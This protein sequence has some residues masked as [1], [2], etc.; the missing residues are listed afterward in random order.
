MERIASPDRDLGERYGVR[1][2][3]LLILVNVW[4]PIA[5][6]CPDAG[7]SRGD[8]H[9]RGSASTVTCLNV[10]ACAACQQAIPKTRASILTNDFAI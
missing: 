5:G 4:I 9:Q 7:A 6:Q 1:Q 8:L 10:C 3:K 2:Y